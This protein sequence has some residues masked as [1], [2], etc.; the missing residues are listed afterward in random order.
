MLFQM[1]E[2]H[3]VGE[4]GKNAEKV[5]SLKQAQEK[6]CISA[7]DVTWNCTQKNASWV[8][9]SNYIFI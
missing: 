1:Q 2:R 8:T 7:R 5:C 3:S 6:M 4:E 9:T